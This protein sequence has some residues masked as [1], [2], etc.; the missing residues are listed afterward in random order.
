MYTNADNRADSINSDHTYQDLYPVKTQTPRSSNQ[1]KNS[2]NR[3]TTVCLV[4]LCVLLLSGITVLW[5]KY[6]NVTTERWRFFSSSIYY[7]SSDKK[8]WNDTRKYC[9]ERGADLV[10][11]NSAEEQAF[12]SKYYGSDQA[13]IG[14]TDIVREGDFKW[15]DGSP[16]IT[17]FW[18]NDEPNNA[19]VEEDCVITASRFAEH[20]ILTWNDFPCD[21]SAVGICEMKLF[22]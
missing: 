2:G 8:N 3:L 18:S 6:N 10:I 16:L 11:I 22:N 1:S 20:N 14:L 19:V 15:V 5:I 21:F 9:R 13:W 12:I 17:A 4:L 7:V